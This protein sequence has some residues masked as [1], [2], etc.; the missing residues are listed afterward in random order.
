MVVSGVH[1]TEVRMD[2]QATSIEETI[3]QRADAWLEA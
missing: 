3:R 1:D 2:L